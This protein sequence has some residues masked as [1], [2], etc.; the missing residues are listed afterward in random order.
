MG[1]V[2]GFEI[3]SS[4]PGKRLFASFYT[5]DNEALCSVRDLHVVYVFR[6]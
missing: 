4:G 6:C 3:G 1:C 2:L 5:Q